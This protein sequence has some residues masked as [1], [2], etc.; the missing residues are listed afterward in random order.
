ML[1]LTK[2]PNCTAL[3]LPKVAHLIG[4]PYYTADISADILQLPNLARFLR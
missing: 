2:S 1:K 3:K 4:R